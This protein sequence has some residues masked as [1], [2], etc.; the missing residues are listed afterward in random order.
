MKLL[1]KSLLALATAAAMATPAFAVPVNVGGIVW[2]PDSG[3]DFSMGGIF[4]QAFN[5]PAAPLGSILSGYG[6]VSGING[7]T[8]FCQAGPNCKLTFVF[9]GYVLA[10]G[11]GLTFPKTFNNGTIKLF[12]DT[13]VAAD[14]SIAT[15]SDGVLWADMVANPLFG[16]SLFV[17]QAFTNAQGTGYL[18]VIGGLA[19]GNLDTNVFLGADLSFGSTVSLVNNNGGNGTFT[20]NGNSVPE[21]GSLALLG[22]GLV[23]L[24]A[25]RR[26]KAA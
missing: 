1:K 2:D 9:D 10:A 5:N 8:N 24:A 23:G 11:A 21:P 13:D 4:S 25:A 22:L 16:F 14:T 12:V 20:L 6:E 19:Q 26:R 7:L 3:I 15:A 17:A 18:D